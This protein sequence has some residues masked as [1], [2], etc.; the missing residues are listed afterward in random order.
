MLFIFCSAGFI[1]L[2][3]IH[4]PPVLSSYPGSLSCSSNANY[5]YFVNFSSIFSFRLFPPGLDMSIN[6]IF[7][8]IIFYGYIWSSCTSGLLALVIFC[9][10]Y[11]N[12]NITFCLQSQL[13]FSCSISPCTTVFSLVIT[14]LV[15]SIPNKAP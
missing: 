11:S 8:C 6:S 7:S 14:L 10:W 12:S 15:F 1:P 5:L 13:L 3:D 2:Q 4:L 9:R